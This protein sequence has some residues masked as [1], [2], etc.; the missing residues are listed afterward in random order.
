M[1]IYILSADEYSDNHIVGVYDSWQSAYDKA[2]FDNQYAIEVRGINST[3]FYGYHWVVTSK[4][5]P[6]R[7]EY[8]LQYSRDIDPTEE[9]R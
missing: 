1:K 7:Y 8:D 4:Y 6:Y 9:Q 3:D 2:S 5:D